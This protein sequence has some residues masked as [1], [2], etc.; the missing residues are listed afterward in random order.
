MW[1]AV[2]DTVHRRIHVPARS[3]P[4]DRLG[5]WAEVGD[6]EIRLHFLLE[7]VPNNL[8]PCRVP[9]FGSG[10]EMGIIVIGLHT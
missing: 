10:R 7:Y 6:I 5:R 3:D 2:M 4:I 1:T 9:G 8:K